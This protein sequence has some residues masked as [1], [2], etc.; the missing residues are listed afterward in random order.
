MSSKPTETSSIWMPLQQSLFR[1]VWIAALASSIGTW[2]QSV[3][4]SWLMTTLTPSA[5]L[6][7]L[8]QSATSLPIL[9]IGLI[10]GALADVVDRRKLLIV[11]Q[12]WMLAAA[13]VFYVLTL[14]GATTPWVL[15]A[16]TFALGLGDA[17]NA[18]AWQAITPDLVPRD[19]L[20]SAVTLNGV[21]VNLARAVGPAIGGFIVAAAGPAPVFLLNAISF[22]G[23]ILVLF[24]WHPT[25]ATSVLPAE[26][27]MGA[28]RA[29]LRYARYARAL[30][31]LLIRTITFILFGS[32]L[33]A[34]L[35]QV[36]NHDLQAGGIGYGLLLGCLG[37]GA[38][39]GATVLLPLRQKFSIDRVVAG[40]SLAFAFATLS[41]ALGTWIA[42]LFSYDSYPFSTASR[43]PGATSRAKRSIC[44][45]D[46]TSGQKMKASKRVARASE[47]STSI[48]YTLILSRGAFPRG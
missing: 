47:V 36:V 41:L 22:L 43:T 9:L 8:M 21:S 37:L 23:V 26:R 38:V 19:A 11:T 28:I 13:A 10:A 20:P 27:V 1:A 45:F 33:W 25:P 34:L 12:S 40:A 7:A 3:G 31:T 24:R 6:V 14:L 5:V 17:M 16:L 35:P 32:A 4:A 29:G 46:E 44:S 18:P 39:I 15:L 48:Q 2:M 42:S 30:D